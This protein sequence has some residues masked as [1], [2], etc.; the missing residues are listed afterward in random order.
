MT[1][2]Y[3]IVRGDQYFKRHKQFQGRRDSEQCPRRSKEET[4]ES[5]REEVPFDLGPQG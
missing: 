3:S 2:Q 5:F 4:E 1:E